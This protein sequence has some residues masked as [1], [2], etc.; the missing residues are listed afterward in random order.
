MADL[1]RPGVPFPSHGFTGWLPKIVNII[2]FDPAWAVKITLVGPVVSSS[3][4]ETDVYGGQQHAPLLG[5]R[6]PVPEDR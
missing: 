6:I 2:Y 1:A 3:M 5:L 4:G